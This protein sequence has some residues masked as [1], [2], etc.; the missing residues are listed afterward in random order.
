MLCITVVIKWWFWQECCG[1]VGRPEGIQCPVTYYTAVGHGGLWPHSQLSPPTEHAII[2]IFYWHY[3]QNLLN[4]QV[5]SLLYCAL[6]LF[7][8]P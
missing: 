4:V 2:T 1:I 5:M 3:R 7:P 8:N 6:L